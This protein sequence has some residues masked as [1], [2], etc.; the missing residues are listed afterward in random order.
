[1]KLLDV[2]TINKDY[3]SKQ[4]QPKQANQLQPKQ[5][6]QL[7]PKQATMSKNDI[8]V[9]YKFRTTSG[10][11]AYIAWYEGNNADFVDEHTFAQFRDLVRRG[12]QTTSLETAVR[13][14]RRIQREET[15]EYSFVVYNGYINAFHEEHGVQ[16]PSSTLRFITNPGYLGEPEDLSTDE[17]LFVSTDEVA[18]L[19][20][21]RN[22]YRMEATSARE[23]QARFEDQLRR[24][25]EENQRLQLALLT[26]ARTA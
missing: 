17:S 21:E 11:I 15:P 16:S 6:N 2:L 5:A 14:A 8:V 22:S 23:A 13:I 24:T 1:M 3:K 19:K 20:A 18:A 10:S 12:K 7:Q 26:L 25:R 9:I 4:L